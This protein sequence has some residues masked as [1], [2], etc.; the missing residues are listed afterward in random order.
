MR[1]D[2]LIAIEKA[3]ARIGLY[4]ALVLLPLLMVARLT[5][6]LTRTF[7]IPG[8]LFNA[9]ESELFMLFAFLTVGAAY[10]NNYHVRVD[11]LRDRFSPRRRAWV[12]LIGIAVMILPFAVI[13]LWFGS[14][15]AGISMADGERAAIG[16]G[17]PV[18]WLI[19]G[20]MPYG[21]LLLFIAM[22]ARAARAI[23]FLRG[24]AADPFEREEMR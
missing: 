3:V 4:S 17:A 7:N 9:M 11:I 23:M 20:A 12:E 13:V 21:M 24:R 19:I 2:T 22:G 8:S 5:E 18:R 1:E 6:I 16:F 14:L 10:A 15:L